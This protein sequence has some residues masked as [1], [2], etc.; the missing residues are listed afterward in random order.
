VAL[1]LFP[2]HM[3]VQLSYFLIVSFNDAV[4]RQDYILSVIKIPS[5]CII[6]GMMMEGENRNNHRRTFPVPL[7][8][9][10]IP[11]RLLWD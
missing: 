1:S 9:P 7:F 4:S 10:E 8:P 5:L 3:Y 11:H 2:F 6:V